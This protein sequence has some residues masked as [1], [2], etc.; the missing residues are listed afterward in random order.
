[1][2]KIEFMHAF[3]IRDPINIK[4][5]NTFLIITYVN[6]YKI[7]KTA[8]ILYVTNYYMMWHI[9]TFMRDIKY[10]TNQH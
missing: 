1:M 6:I 4:N 2:C 7:S 9:C 5:I 10:V 3:Q 8:T